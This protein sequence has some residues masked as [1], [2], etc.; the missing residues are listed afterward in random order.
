M[1][2]KEQWKRFDDEDAEYARRAEEVRAKIPKKGT[3]DEAD[4]EQQEADIL[5]AKET[6]RILRKPAEHEPER[7]NPFE[8]RS[9]TPEPDPQT[10]IKPESKPHSIGVGVED[11]PEE[12]T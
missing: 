9:F 8:P 1:A 6:L 7:G 2:T 10:K 12:N 3:V 11:P 5:G 4:P